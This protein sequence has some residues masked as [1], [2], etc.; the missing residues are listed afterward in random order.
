MCGREV[1]GLP[2]DS[3]SVELA[4]EQKPEEGV[5]SCDDRGIGCSCWWNIRSTWE[6]FL[7]FVFK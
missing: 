3:L 7:F 6:G 2:G 4:A 5:P 1:D